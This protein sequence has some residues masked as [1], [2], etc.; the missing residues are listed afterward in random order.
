MAKKNNNNKN[1][2]LTKTKIT[3]TVFIAPLGTPMPTSASEELNEAFENVGYI[4][5]DGITNATDTD[6]TEVA[7][8]GGNTIL[9]VITSYKETY[10]FVML[11]TNKTSLSLRY[12]TENVTG[13]EST[14]LKVVHKMPKGEKHA[15]VLDLFLTGSK[16]KRICIT[17]SGVSEVGDIAY[18]AGTALGYDTTLACDPDDAN[19]GA[20]AIE[21][22]EVIKA[23]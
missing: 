13:D 9:S 22:I 1:V 10:Q 8:M 15:T 7:D 12:E 16:R 14:G 5:E 17:S 4:G 23:A 2:H 19:D 3:G 20:T 6:T 11:E 18:V 21:Y